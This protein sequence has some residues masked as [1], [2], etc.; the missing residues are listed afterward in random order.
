MPISRIIP[1]VAE[2][3]RI[4][5]QVAKDTGAPFVD[6]TPGLAGQ[7]DSDYFYDTVHFTQKGSSV[8]AERMF[9]GI[10]PQLENGPGCKPRE[11]AK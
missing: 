1:A 2:H 10:L 3:N 6:T 8:L 4:A 7:W 11:D 5:R 9:Q